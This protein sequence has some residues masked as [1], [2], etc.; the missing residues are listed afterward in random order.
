MAESRCGAW[1]LQLGKYCCQTEQHL[2]RLTSGE[3]R[4]YQMHPPKG[5]AFP[6]GRESLQDLT[7]HKN[8]GRQ[9][10]P[11]QNKTKGKQEDGGKYF[12]HM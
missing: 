4:R 1:E 7:T 12:P 6:M 3:G 5:E 9:N 8:V 2:R 10:Y 11:R